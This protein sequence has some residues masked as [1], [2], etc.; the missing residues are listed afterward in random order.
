MHSS[1]FYLFWGIL[2]Q[3]DFY[4]FKGID[5]LPD[6]LGYYLIYK[7]LK[8]LA[9]ENKYF[10][11][12]D[13]LIPPIL[14]LSVVKVYNFTY[15]PEFL[16]SFSFALDIV[17]A[18]LFIANMYLVYLLCQ[19][20]IAVAASLEDDYLQTTIKQR[21][22]LYLGV[23][24]VL[25]FLSILSLLPLGEILAKFRSFF[26][27]FYFAYI[28]VVVIIA[29][30]IYGLYKELSPDRKKI[31]KAKSRGKQGQAKRKR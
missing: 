8:T 19:G 27:I 14:A 4:A 7:G 3:L 21:L 22:Y 17:K 31:A 1:F 5:I 30:G 9:E 23:A 16:L 2:L 18:I 28:S 24:A 12:A 29:A 6:V 10:A 11:L 25:V 15:H 26:T 20:S 13:K